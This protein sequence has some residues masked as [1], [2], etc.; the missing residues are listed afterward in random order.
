MRKKSR[1]I[2]DT[3]PK[4]VERENE[5]VPKLKLS[6]SKPFGKKVS[7]KW[8]QLCGREK[9][10]SVSVRSITEIP[11][12]FPSHSEIS[13]LNSVIVIQF[14]CIQHFVESGFVIEVIPTCNRMN[15]GV[16][17]H[18]KSKKNET[19]TIDIPKILYTHV[20]KNHNSLF[21]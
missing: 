7:A 15:V 17:A 13:F 1:W 10:T 2:Y 21:T 3:T 14:F 16:S 12:F 6:I 11:I 4:K 5:R 19:P 20:K 8:Q 9:K 18:G